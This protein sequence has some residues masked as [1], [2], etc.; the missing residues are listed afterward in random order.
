MTFGHDAHIVSLLVVSQAYSYTLV[1]D[2][3]QA[4]E[5]IQ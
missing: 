4:Y 1:P 5:A 3:G 2:T